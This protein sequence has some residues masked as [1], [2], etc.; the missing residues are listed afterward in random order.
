MYSTPL[1]LTSE[2]KWMSSGQNQ[3][4]EVNQPILAKA[5]QPLDLFDGDGSINITVYYYIFD[6]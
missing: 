4:Y 3:G 1:D 5:D 2:Q 6:I